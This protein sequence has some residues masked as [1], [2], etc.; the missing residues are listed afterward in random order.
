[1][2]EILLHTHVKPQHLA[3]Y[4]TSRRSH[5]WVSL[6]LDQ[7]VDPQS[8]IQLSQLRLIL[9]AEEGDE[10]LEQGFFIVPPLWCGGRT[11]ELI[12]LRGDALAAERS[13]EEAR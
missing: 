1:M 5:E 4:M 6:Y 10:L 7:F 9:A 13:Q 8:S 12:Q 2:L 3:P 11:Q